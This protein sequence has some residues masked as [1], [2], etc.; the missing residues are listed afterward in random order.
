MTSA[1]LA[2]E[3][4]VGAKLYLDTN[5][6]I[7]FVEGHDR[8]APVLSQLFDMIDDKAVV[9][10]TSELTFA[11]VM[12][13]AFADGN[14]HVA[15]IYERLLFGP[16]ELTVV[17]ISRPVL[18]RSAELRARLPLRAFDAIHVATAAE[19]TCDFLI[20]QDLRIRAPDPIKILPLT[21]FSPDKPT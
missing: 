8:F 13:K 7:Y 14:S 18:R 10:V 3:G 6:F 4:F 19:T 12:V 5:V 17:P 11:E 21:D 9:A 2:F 16:S 15:A 20:S 1:K